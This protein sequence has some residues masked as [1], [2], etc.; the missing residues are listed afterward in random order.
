MHIAL[1]LWNSI[2]LCIA[3]SLCLF[4][5]YN[6]NIPCC[7]YLLISDLKKYSPFAILSSMYWFKSVLTNCTY[8]GL[9]SVQ[10]L[11][12]FLALWSKDLLLSRRL[13]N[14][15]AVWRRSSMLFHKEG[16]FSLLKWEHPFPLGDQTASTL[17]N[18]L[19]NNSSLLHNAS[20]LLPIFSTSYC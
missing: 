2:L 17:H 14:V 9:L 4:T 8:L 15:G 12:E 13:C 20:Y 16:L 10:I 18:N 6:P 3:H 1:D 19:L 11:H 7:I 5:F